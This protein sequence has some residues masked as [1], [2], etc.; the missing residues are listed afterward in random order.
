MNV[1]IK[2]LPISKFFSQY[3]Q[4]NLIA[5]T[6]YTHQLPRISPGKLRNKIYF[7]LGE[8]IYS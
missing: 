5:H 7:V 2:M 3:E 6:S 4:S 1:G 8:L